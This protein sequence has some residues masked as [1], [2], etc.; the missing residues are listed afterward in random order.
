MG[1]AKCSNVLLEYLSS[2]LFGCQW[3]LGKFA[4]RL[5]DCVIIIINTYRVLYN[6]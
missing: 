5:G 3:P 4:G 2:R 6:G 1:G